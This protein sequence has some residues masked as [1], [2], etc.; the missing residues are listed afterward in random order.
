L[1]AQRF[2]VAATS[3]SALG[4][5]RK[6]NN[7]ELADGT[8]RYGAQ[9]DRADTGPGREAGLPGHRCESGRPQRRPR[10]PPRRSQDGAQP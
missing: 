8:I 2:F 1:L 7:T 3:L 4:W 9:L 6:P 5:L 10:P